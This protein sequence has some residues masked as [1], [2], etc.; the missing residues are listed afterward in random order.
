MDR[1]SFIFLGTMLFV[2]PEVVFGQNAKLKGYVR[3]AELNQPIVGAT[4]VVVGGAKSV[5]SNAEGKYSLEELP[6]NQE[7]VL[8]VGFLGYAPSTQTVNLGKGESRDLDI[9]LRTRAN[10][11]QGLTIEDQASRGA[12]M[13]AISTKPIGAL[14]NPSGNFEKLLQAYGASSNN[15]FSSQYTVR[16]GNFDENLIIV[17][18]IEI[19]RPYLVRTGQQEGLSF[20]NPDLV[21]SIKFS[22]GGFEAKYGDKLSSVLDIQYRKPKAAK[23]GVSAS[24]MG[25][26][27][28]YENISKNQRLTYSVAARYRT[29]SNLLRTLDTEGTYRPAATDLQAFFTYNTQKNWQF[30]LLA[31]YG[32][33]SYLSIPETR[34]SVFGNIKAARRLT[35]AFDGRDKTGYQTSTIG[36]TATYSPN[37]QLKLKFTASGYTSKEYENADIEGA[38]Y[39]EE[40]ETD[41]GSKN[42]GK[43]KATLGFG[44][45]HNFSRNNLYA[46]IIALE[47]KGVFDAKKKGFLQWGVRAQHDYISDRLYEWYRVDSAE[48][49]IAPGNDTA[50]VINFQEFLQAKNKV[51]SNRFS[52][53]VQNTYLLNSAYDLIFTAGIRANYWSFN[54]ETL[55]SP[56]FQLS[57]RPFTSDLVLRISAGVYNQPAFYRELRGLTGVVNTQN[58]AQ[59]SQQI[60]VGGDL[61]FKAWGRPF[62]FVTEAYY[63]NMS[64]IIPYEFD[65][66]RLRYYAT[67]QSKGY[68]TGIDFRVNGE[69][70][71][72]LESWASLS[73]LST[74]EDVIGD[75]FINANGER[76]EPGYIRRPTDQKFRFSIMFQDYLPK[77]P[78]YKVSLNL[79]YASRLPAGPPDYNR[80]KDEIYS[81]PPYRRVDIGFSKQLIGKGA[82]FKT[83]TAL[84]NFKS[85]WLSAEV[86]N[87]FQIQNTI[88]YLW[89]REFT[90][91][92]YAVPN[93][94]SNR[95][96]NVRIVGEF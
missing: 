62:K 96:I 10:Q 89:V 38:Y 80:Y 40:I 28:H 5:V 83:E 18:D 34:T 84:K 6:S 4:I 27:A 54:Q 66:V 1:L 74:K 91:N 17:N 20:I 85:L 23:G 56:R 25:G 3:D 53:F 59:R 24:F 92:Q 58:K 70:V 11:L 57:M 64:R 75:F 43:A 52:G 32:A 48:F 44:A 61:N 37:N 9:F 36:S 94:L 8:S 67:E 14:P 73:L 42:F 49:A 12:P 79:V 82:N 51:I 76:I 33:N 69:F 55:I 16:G 60:V 19:Y 90:G 13:A 2:L 35:V 78:T 86:F 93:Y 68:A 50:Q 29:L 15:E 7:I 88:S 46:N 95:T 30:S 26:S 45:F 77:N 21:E 65:N 81:I 22:A 41:L 39:L 47:H 31:N 63:K 72:T 87:L 71:N